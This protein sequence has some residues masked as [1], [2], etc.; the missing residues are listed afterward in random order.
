VVAEPAAVPPGAPDEP[1]TLDFADVHAAGLA[2]GLS[3]DDVAKAVYWEYA[4]QHPESKLVYYLMYDAL[5]GD[6]YGGWAAVVRLFCSVMLCPAV[7]QTATCACWSRAVRVLR[8][9]AWHCMV[10]RGSHCPPTRWLSARTLVDARTWRALA[11]RLTSAPRQAAV[12]GLEVAYRARLRQRMGTYHQELVPGN[13]NG[14]NAVWCT[15]NAV[16]RALYLRD[17]VAAAFVPMPDAG[18]PWVLCNRDGDRLN[19][20]ADNLE[21]RL[22]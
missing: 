7:A 6:E 8:L 18:G 17:L 3:A 13:H 4:V 9:A 12:S 22:Q 2:F 14:Y 5:E 16:S 20:D 15:I 1:V 11:P 10:P 19:D 21:W